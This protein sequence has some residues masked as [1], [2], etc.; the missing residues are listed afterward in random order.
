MNQLHRVGRE[1]LRLGRSRH[2][3]T[4]TDVLTS[5]LRQQGLKDPFAKR[6]LAQTRK[7]G[8]REHRHETR[9]TNKQNTQELAILVT[10]LTEC[11]YPGQIIVRQVFH[12]VDG[13]DESVIRLR[14][15]RQ[16]A[17]QAESSGRDQQRL[18]SLLMGKY[19]V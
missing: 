5:L 6:L 2:L 8:L 17:P 11:S 1:Y 12:L 14:L 10:K 19:G 4:V 16:M 3:E 15:F 18:H 7:L 9:L 13:D